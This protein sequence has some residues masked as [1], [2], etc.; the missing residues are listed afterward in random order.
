MKTSF[1]IENFTLTASSWAHMA[2]AYEII[3]FYVCLCV[4]LGVILYAIFLFRLLLLFY[5]PKMVKRLCFTLCTYYSCLREQ[6]VKLLCTTYTCMLL[7]WDGR[8]G[9]I[10]TLHQMNE[11]RE[12]HIKSLPC[13]LSNKCVCVYLCERQLAISVFITRAIPQHI[14]VIWFW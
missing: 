10:I 4:F 11:I 12:K 1:S 8:K 3:H 7:V 5:I 13:W 2:S 14:S 6:F 9:V